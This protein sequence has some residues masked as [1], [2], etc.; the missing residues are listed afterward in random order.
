MREAEKRLL[1]L[2]T[3]L[4]FGALLQRGRLAR[5]DVILDQ[6]LLLDGHV[7]KAMGAAV[8]VGAAGFRAL[9]N[10]GMARPEVKPLKIGGVVGGAALFGVGLAVT[11]YCP[12]TGVAAAG[13]GQG[14][15][16]AGVAGMLA[17]AA[18][19][20]ALHSKIAP[21]LDAGGDYG[22]ITLDAP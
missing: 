3:G 17:G 20:V 19:F 13:E 6:L 18:G 8:A 11:G 21:L 22:K 2:A 7:A 14:D 4:V 9:R 15:A 5:R 10:N 1:G 16:M 12:G